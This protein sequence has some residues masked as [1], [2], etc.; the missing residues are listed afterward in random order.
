MPTSPASDSTWRRL[1]FFFAAIS[2]ATVL[3][4][5]HIADGDLWGKLAIG[6]YF[7]HFGAVPDHDLFAFTPVLPHYI[8]HEWGAGTIFFGVLKF[9]GPTGLMLLKMLLAFGAMLAA[10]AV[11]RKHNCSWEALLLLAGPVAWFEMLGYIPVIRSHAFTYCFFAMT[12][13]ALE[14]I[15]G[16]KKWPLFV[17]PPL[18]AVWSNVHGGMLAGCG[19]VFVYTAFAFFAG[20]ISRHFSSPRCCRPRQAR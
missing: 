11:G 5:Y 15:R 1:A 9:F 10:L 12:L 16:G 6:A 14:E 3:A 4:A 19:A 17:L 2:F 18:F 8:E 7:W 20:K 13:L